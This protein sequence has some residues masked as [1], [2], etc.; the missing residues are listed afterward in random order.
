[1]YKFY[2]DYAKQ[3]F[4][5]NLF[6]IAGDKRISF[7]E[8]IPIFH[9]YR[10]KKPAGDHESF[11]EGLKVFDRDGKGMINAAEARHLLTSLGMKF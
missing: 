10:Q 4:G 2:S 5:K 7:E 8:F 1:M 11:V 9:T 6:L 3:I